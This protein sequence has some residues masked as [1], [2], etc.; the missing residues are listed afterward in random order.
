MSKKKRRE[1]ESH[2]IL[3]PIRY[4]EHHCNLHHNKIK[5]VVVEIDF[6]V[7]AMKT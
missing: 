1:R 5:E 6:Y 2:V 7:A 3:N 4:G